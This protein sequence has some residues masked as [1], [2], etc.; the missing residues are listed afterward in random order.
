MAAELG[1]AFS[2]EGAL[3]HGFLPVV[4]GADDPDFQ[5]RSYCGFAKCI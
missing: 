4:V 3:R 5:L 2:F 1:E